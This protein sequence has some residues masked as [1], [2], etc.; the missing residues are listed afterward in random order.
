MGPLIWCE[1][2]SV[3]IRAID[4]EH[5]LLIEL[6]N[7]LQHALE[8]QEMVRSQLVSAALEKL[9]HHI[10]AHFE[11]EERFLLFNNYPDFDIHQQE[12]LELLKKLEQFVNHISSEQVV[13]TEKMLLFLKD[14]LVRHIILHDC[15]Y[16]S[17][18]LGQELASR[19][20]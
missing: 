4:N 1:D 13:F 16:G 8:T 9:K 18:Y 2:Y 5:K 17:Y 3:N 15:K 12:H 14:W 10:R 11:S 20:S 7:D 6:I 19:F